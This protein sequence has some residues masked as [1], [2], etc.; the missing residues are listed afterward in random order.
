M[1]PEGA[2]ET[3]ENAAQGDQAS[4]C[5]LGNGNRSQAVLGQPFDLVT[6]KSAVVDRE[7]VHETGEPR[8]GV[9]AGA[10][11]AGTEAQRSVGCAG[12]RAVDLEVIIRCG[13]RQLD[14]VEEQA[15]VAAA[16]IGWP[17]SV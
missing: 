15:H 14:A 2:A 16:G 10:E 6:R 4:R 8:A 3:D 17:G 7:L 13:G 11:T 9:R 5:R 1:T 12:V